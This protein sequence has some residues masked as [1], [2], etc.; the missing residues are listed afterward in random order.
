MI[1][2]MLNALA[3]VVAVHFGIKSARLEGLRTDRALSIR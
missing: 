3:F 2:S 1:C